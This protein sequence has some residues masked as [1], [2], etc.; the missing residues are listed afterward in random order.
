MTVSKEIGS[1]TGS[2]AEHGFDAQPH[3]FLRGVGGLDHDKSNVS[4]PRFE[5]VDGSDNLPNQ[6]VAIARRGHC[7]GRDIGQAVDVGGP[8]DFF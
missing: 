1:G 8:V 5:E 7:Q 6:F 4:Q 2:H 3:I